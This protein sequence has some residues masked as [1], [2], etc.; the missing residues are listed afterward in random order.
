M[1]TSWASLLIGGL[2][3]DLVVQLRYMHQS[4][5]RVGS[6]HRLSHHF[7]KSCCINAR[8]K[9][10]QMRIASRGAMILT[11]LGGRKIQAIQAERGCK[12]EADQAGFSDEL[13]RRRG[14]FSAKSV[15][16]VNQCM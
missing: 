16:N 3:F 1:R 12:A 10:A 13:A 11:E 6:M 2:I 5:S 8:F 15:I 4:T 7:R 9:Y 14:K